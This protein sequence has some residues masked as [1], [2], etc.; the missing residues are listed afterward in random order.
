MVDRACGAAA[1]AISAALLAGCGG[2]RASRPVAVQVLVPD[3]L[4]PEVATGF[5]LG[6][7]RVLT[8]AHVLDPRRVGARLRV[9]VPGRP[10]RAATVASIDERDDLVT[11]AVPG[12]VARR[13]RFAGAAG[14][15]GVLV[16]RAGRVRLLPV[17][18]RRTI[19]A[20]IRTPDGRRVVR[21][22]A[23]EL[24]ADVLPGD[25]GAPVLDR[26]GRVTAI[27]FA[28]SNLR[29]RT[30]YAVDAPRALGN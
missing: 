21:R 4:A 1:F 24:Q 23:V 9:R 25:S 2:Q 29:G 3:G 10:T 30:A 13:P 27:V 7:G 8:V 12:L 16:V 18:V 14:G 17:R 26:A 20:T 6:P 28:R 5:A 22:P 19:V 15:A 11:L